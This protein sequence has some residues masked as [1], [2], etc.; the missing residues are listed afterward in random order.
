MNWLDTQMAVLDAATGAVG[1][2]INWLLQST[3]L[4][5]A[6]L[7]IGRLLRTRGSAVQ[8]VVLRT[9]LAAVLVCPLATQGLSLAGVSGWS[10]KMPRAWSRHD[11]DDLISTVDSPDPATASGLA[12]PIGT[13]VLPT[14]LPPLFAEERG[15]ENTASSQPTSLAFDETSTIQVPSIIAGSSS[16]KFPGPQTAGISIHRFGM[17]SLAVMAIWLCVSF[18]LTSRLATAWKRLSRLRREAVQADAN[19]IEICQQFASRLNVSAPDVLRSPCLPSPCLAGIRRPA[20]L[21]PEVD[22]SLSI[23]EVLIHELAHLKRRDCHWNLLR[24]IATAAF[25]FQPL[26]WKLSRALESAAEE[27]CDDYVVEFGGDRQEYAHGLVDIAELSS[28]PVTVAGVGIVSLRSMLAKRVSRIMDTSR[29]L[30]TRVG[31]LLLVCVIAGGL[32]GTTITGFLGLG[33]RASQAEVQ[34]VGNQRD[35]GSDKEEQNLANGVTAEDNDLITVHVQ[36][37]T[38][39]EYEGKVVDPAGTPVEDAH[40]YL[41]F[42]IPQPTGLLTPTWKPVATTGSKGAF[43]F[44]ASPADFGVHAT[45]REFGYSTLVA[46]KPGFGFA[47]SQAGKYETSG[48][49]LRDARNRLNE[50]PAEF[51]E[52]VKHMLSGAGEPLQLVMDD[53]PI[54]GRIVDINGQPVTGA[55]LTLLEVGSGIGDDLTA[56]REAADAPKSDYYSARMKTPVSMNGPQV[57]SLVKPAVTDNDGSFTLRGVGN[58]RIAELLLEGPGIESA[59]IFTRTEAGEQITLL[60]ERRSPDLGSYIYYPAELTYVAGPSAAVT[61]VVRDA[62][63][64]EPLSG[65][66]VKSQSR[67]GEQINGWGQDFVRAVTDGEGKFRLEGMPIGSDNRIAAIAPHGRCGLLL[68]EQTSINHQPR[69]P[70]GSR[71]RFDERRVDRRSHHG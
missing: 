69:A 54:R 19:T 3:M 63:T 61:G 28:V 47:W 14:A 13:P 18:V 45:E 30:S 66:T 37:N 35:A 49:W 10:V 4:I 64:H 68:N 23:R 2:A 58:G 38:S 7:T 55:R 31:N 56:W 20:V 71:F 34:S 8:S 57:R 46:V 39:R 53:Q 42:H 50:V 59:K 5:A 16:E 60:R 62:Q 29:T 48:K 43:R 32:L 70:A 65:V 25:F 33:P 40:L 24:Q 41:V 1:F 17:V 44:T 21:L 67:H 51:L 11:A 22:K 52:Q 26:L 6:G 36:D 15:A 12:E 27:V 9:T